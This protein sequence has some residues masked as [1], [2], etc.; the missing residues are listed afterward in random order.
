MAVTDYSE[1]IP[2]AIAK[3]KAHLSEPNPGCLWPNESEV[4]L[5]KALLEASQCRICREKKLV[6]HFHG[7][8]WQYPPALIAFTEK[9]ESVSHD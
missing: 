4:A 8:P 7:K 6:T 2:A 9:I 3:G 5:A 1:R